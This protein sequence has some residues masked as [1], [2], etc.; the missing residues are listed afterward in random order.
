M[1]AQSDSQGPRWWSVLC[2]TALLLLTCTAQ[3][4]DV[5][6][7]RIWRAPDST[8]LVLDL[9]APVEHSLLTLSSP[10]RLVVDIKGGRLKS[11]SVLAK[12]DLA[13]SPIKR[14]RSAVKDKHDLR[15]VLD[16]K[17]RVKPR[18]FLLRAD[19]NL[20]DRL[21]IDLYDRATAKVE[22]KK[23]SVNGKRDIIIAIDP[24]HGGEDPGAS[25]PGGIK[26]KKVVF[27]IAKQ[28]E[29]ILKQQ[30]GYRPFLTRTGDYYVGL[31]Q[32]PALARKQRADMFVSI[33]ADAF[34]S[35]KPRGASVFALSQ[36]GSTSAMARHLADRENR[37]DLAGGVTLSD[38]D[39]VLAGVLLD[40]SM[41]ANLDASLKVGGK[42]LRG[43]GSFA[44]LHSKRV[45]QAGFAVLKSAD[46]PSIL[47]ETGFISNP[48]EARK[49]ATRSYQRKMAQA[50][51]KGI[52]QYFTAHPPSG[53]LLAAKMS[54]RSKRYTVVAGDTLSGIAQRYRVSVSSLKRYNNMSSSVVRIGQHLN[55]P[56]S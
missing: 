37:A 54:G 52:D 38:K 23:P 14:I 34:S 49:L 39:D 29:A 5:V 30:P 16:L 4:S 28:L 53:T 22:V 18:S 44:H 36:R 7:A 19:D 8:R 43:V 2:V 55:I 33:H 42:V 51:F 20:N 13:S 48:A 15:I 3:A 6:G 9:S 40:L 26:E 41:T 11:S 47:V 12:L 24:G 32:R 10:D 31:S 46:I 45:E 27:A 17:E 56:A 1:P 50:I 25:G 21:V 35:P